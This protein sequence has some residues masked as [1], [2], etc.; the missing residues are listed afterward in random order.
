MKPAGAAVKL[1]V[2]A[3]TARKV[4]CPGCGAFYLAPRPSGGCEGGEVN[5][6]A[7]QPG[8]WPTGWR[9]CRRPV[10]K[11]SGAGANGAVSRRPY[12]RCTPENRPD[13]APAR[14]AGPPA[15]C[16]SLATTARRG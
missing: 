16:K 15:E 5:R 13:S 14:P 10:G 2:S 9:R 1:D 11:A 12:L 3:K 6:E 4:R 8:R 7:P